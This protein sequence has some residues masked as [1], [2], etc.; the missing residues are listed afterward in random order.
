MQ[1][2]S[3]LLSAKYTVQQ[4]CMLMETGGVL[5]N[6]MATLGKYT[7]TSKLKLSITK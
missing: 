3:I 6:D 2:I 1:T 7:Q 5:R 4:L